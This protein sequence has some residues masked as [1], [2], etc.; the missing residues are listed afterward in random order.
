MYQPIIPAIHKEL[1]KRDL[2]NMTT[3]LM[4]GT[5]IATISYVLCGVFGYVTFAKNPDVKAIMN[6]SNLLQADYAGN[7][8]ILAC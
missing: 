7:N 3:V 5:T 6:K 8:V 2:K 1:V 4:L